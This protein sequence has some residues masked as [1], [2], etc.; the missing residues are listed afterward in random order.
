MFIYVFITTYN[1]SQRLKI[2]LDDLLQKKGKHKLQI[3]VYDDASTLRYDFIDR[4]IEKYNIEYVKFDFNHGRYRYWRL[5]N[6]A[7]KQIRNT[8]YDYYIMLPDDVTLCNEF[9]KRAINTWEAI[10]DNRKICLNLLLDRGRR[11]IANWTGFKPV[12][13]KY[14]G[15]EI[16][17]TQ[18]V[19][20]CFIADKRFFK[21]VRYRVDSI[22]FSRWQGKDCELL[23]SGVG[24]QVSEKLNRSGWHLYQ[25]TDTLVFHGDHPSVM[26]PEE[27]RRSRLVT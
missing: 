15:F 16:Y 21:E 25:V 10:R 23:S 2:L 18:W 17:R 1:R 3:V 24:A 8:K 12:K 26:N 6:Y 4:Y 22:D 9:F 11:G 14:G 5:I 13:V 7:F 20:L 19:D 27:R